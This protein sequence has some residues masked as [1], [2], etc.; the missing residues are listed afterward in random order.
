MSSGMFPKMTDSRFQ[1]MIDPRSVAFD[2]DS[3]IADTMAL[4][5]DIAREEHRIDHL[6]YE[7]IT[8]YDLSACLNL[9][10]PVIE[11]IVNRIQ[12]G[13]YRAAL[14]PIPGA[15]EV[16]AKVGKCHSPLLFVTAR[17]YAG[18]IRDWVN[19][20]LA[21]NPSEVEI[22]ATGSFDDKVD[23]LTGRKITHFVEDRLETCYAL[24]AGGV[25]PILFRQ[26]WN[27]SRHPFTEVG[28]WQ[29][30]ESLI[31]FSQ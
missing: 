3:V 1:K 10:L 14:K 2:I 25:T 26:P 27:R 20:S 28:S 9:S 31:C 21:L 17:P 22:V 6:K 29:E 5:I 23:V 30:L 4:F 8:A 19:E 11:A 16:L 15:A 24:Q 7:D 18:P 12:D 13:G